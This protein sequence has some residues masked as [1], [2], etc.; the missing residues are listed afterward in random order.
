[1][2]DLVKKHGHFYTDDW[3]PLREMLIKR[4]YLKKNMI[5]QTI[6]NIRTMLKYS[7]I[8]SDKEQVGR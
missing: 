8:P 1:M 6:K 2:P 3:P 5:F 7:T 4:Y